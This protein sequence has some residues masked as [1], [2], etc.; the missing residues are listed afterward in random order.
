MS[1]IVTIGGGT[2]TFTVLL[3]LKG[4]GHELSAVVAMSDDGGSTGRLR[5]EMGVLPPGDIRQALVA[6]SGEEQLMLDLFNY[7][8]GKG[9]LS[10][11]NFGNLLLAALEKI[12]GDFEKAV[13]AAQKILK[14][15]GQVIPVTTSETE[16]F[17]KLESGQE[18]A[19]ENVIDDEPPESLRDAL[20]SEIYLNPHVQ[21]TEKARQAISSADLIL[22]GPGDFWGSLMANLVVDGVKEALLNSKAKK[23]LVLNL[24]TR[25]GQKG[26]KA[27]DYLS[28]VEKYTKLDYVLINNTDFNEE[29][30][31]LYEKDYEYPVEDDLG[32]SEECL[33]I[34]S[35]LLS[36]KTY[37]QEETDVVK[38]SLLRHDSA[39]IAEA[40]LE[41]LNSEL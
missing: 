26:F 32:E 9:N 15:E 12:T 22:L 19:G 2:G 5:T 27:S 8:F 11:H 33:V 23:V 18:V 10:G 14:V 24:M 41:I 25:W 39:K 13:E 17:V 35:D 34:R 6:L 31:K 29:I 7:R 38:R 40:V 20:V 36:V 4:K 3:G 28:W 1:K 21:I 16:L 30:V 37:K